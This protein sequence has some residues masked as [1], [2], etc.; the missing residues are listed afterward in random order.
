[1]L[2]NQHGALTASHTFCGIGPIPPETI[3]D[4]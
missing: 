1:M 2:F 3:I 4:V